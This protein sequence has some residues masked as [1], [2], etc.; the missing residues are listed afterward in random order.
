MM[1]S[2]IL[3]TG[4]SGFIGRA[5]TAKLRRD[6]YC[7]REAVRT[8]AGADRVAIGHIGLATDWHNALRGVDCVI[9][10]A[11]RVHRLKDNVA[12]PLSA[13]RAV[14]TAGTLR[15]A[16]QAADAGVRRF[17]FVSSVKV[18]GE[19]TT[20]DRPFTS[21]DS[22]APVDPYGQSKAEAERELADMAAKAR[23]ELV[24]VRP[25]LV[26]GPGVKANFAA[27]VGLVRRGWPLPF[28]AITENRRSM[29]AIDNLTD[30]L[31]HCVRHPEAAGQVFL[32]SDGEDVS[33]AELVQRIAA[34][35][36]RKANLVSLPPELLMAVARIAGK[37]AVAERLLGSLRVDISSARA[38]LGWSPPV[39]MQDALLGAVAPVSR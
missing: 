35:L 3:V 29:I 4:A 12:D 8:G 31:A 25:S 38:H 26:Y 22:P 30:L 20:A 6:G 10:C 23:L 11:A 13:F 17:V 9:H 34:A 24:V 32:A 27:L 2:P 36:G 21:E 7:V 28:G 37:A 15:L 33:T 16:Q 19:Q 18:N 39:T 1:S 14:N 5:L